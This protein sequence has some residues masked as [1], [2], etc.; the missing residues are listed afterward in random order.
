MTFPTSGSGNLNEQQ[1]VNI[2]FICPLNPVAIELRDRIG[3]TIT[4]S[5]LVPRPHLVWPRD[6]DRKV[7]VKEL[8]VGTGI[9]DERVSQCC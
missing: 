1:Q 5:S 9:S 2:F 7:N 6:Y 3:G 4:E 8:K